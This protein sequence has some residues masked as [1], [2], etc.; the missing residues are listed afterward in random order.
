[1]AHLACVTGGTG[2]VAT[3]LIKQL[4]EKGYS[5]RATVRDAGDAAKVGALLRLGEALPG[6]E[7]VAQVAGQGTCGRGG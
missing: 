2:F 7:R 5:V 6:A 1:M 3:E 4:L